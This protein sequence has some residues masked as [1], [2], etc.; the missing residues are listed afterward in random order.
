[1]EHK[2]MLNIACESLEYSTSR[3]IHQIEKHTEE[4]IIKVPVNCFVKAVHRR[5]KLR[6][7]NS[8]SVRLF[9]G[10]CLVRPLTVIALQLVKYV[11]FKV[12][13]YS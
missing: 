10:P 12:K 3:N 5:A 9:I 7:A 1:M 2:E 4:I 6:K 8:L 11:L 13:R